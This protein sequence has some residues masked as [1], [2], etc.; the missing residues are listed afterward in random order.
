MNKTF[1]FVYVRTFYVNNLLFT[2]RDVNVT[3]RNDALR[4][5]VTNVYFHTAYTTRLQR[6]YFYIYVVYV[7]PQIV[8]T[9]KNY[10]ECTS[11]F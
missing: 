5:K 4:G 6:S 1:M 11:D 3:S 8:Y 10:T 7:I 9:V 2:C